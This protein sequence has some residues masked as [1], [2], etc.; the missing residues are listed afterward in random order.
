MTDTPETTILVID[1]E[2]AVRQ[3]FSDYL[4]DMG[5]RMLTAENGRDGIEVFDTEAVDLVLVDLRMPEMDGLEV[6]AHIAKKYPDTPSI[7]ISGTGVISDAVEALHQGAWDYLLKPVRDM[8][9]LAHAVEMVLEKSRLKRENQRYQK[10]LEKMVAERTRALEQANENLRSI[11][12]NLRAGIVIVEDDTRNISYMNPSAAEMISL[13][14][15]EAL[16]LKRHDIFSVARE[17]KALLPDPGRGVNA[18]EVLLKTADGRSV[19]VLKTKTRVVFG[20]EDC[21]LESFVDLTDQK[22][23]AKEKMA[24]ETQLRQV[25]KMEALGT[26]AGGIAH[27]FNNILGAIIGYAEL[28]CMDLNDPA[29]PVHQKLKSILHAGNRARELVT[30][31]L[32]FSRMQEQILTPI[33]IDPVINEALKLL[34]ASLPAD[35]QLKTTINTRQKVMADATQIHQVVMN[36]CTNAYHAMERNGGTLSV[37][38]ETVLREAGD[39][40]F[41]V[42]LPAGQYLKLSVE[43][44]GSGISASVLDSIFDPY[45]STKK[46]DKGTGLGLSVVHGIVK[47]HGGSIEVKSQIGEG[48]V[49]HVFLPATDDDTKSSAEQILPLPR[50]NEKILLVDD[51]QDLVDI[52]SRM[53]DHLGYDVTGVVGSP[54]ALETF[55]KT[56]ERFDLVITDMNMPAMTGD[57]L[58]AEIVRIRPEIP[59]LLCTGFSERIEENRLRAAGIRKLV[60]KPLAMNRLALAVREVLDETRVQNIDEPGGLSGP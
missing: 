29:H 54:D 6:L 19:P 4:E 47:G 27:D 32:T 43:D 45:F 26:L 3:S 20:G 34:K 24:F 21:L 50:G 30:Q 53:L 12:D 55:K 22:A 13:P 31:I 14:I 36:L 56:H 16:G 5:H 60:M 11:L 38:L 9:V 7:V 41:P 23:A 46:K 1:D 15:E 49:F 37:S 39:R 28:S 2:D 44:T 59:I 10:H 8:S 48:S 35:I 51:E 57:R 40:D 25:Q 33:R 17:D 52:G 42:D 18:E 58:A